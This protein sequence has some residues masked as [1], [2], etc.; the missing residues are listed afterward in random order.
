MEQLKRETLDPAQIKLMCKLT[1]P[2]LQKRKKT[3][4]T[5]L[6]REV[7]YKSELINGYRYKFYGDDDNL[8]AI[9][10]FIKTERLC[11]DFFNFNLEISPEGFIYL[12]LTGPAGTK[13]FIQSEIEL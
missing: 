1:T 11:C 12:D 5:E 7:L 9:T 3:A 4:I 6:K 13:E 10:E 2:E 8:D